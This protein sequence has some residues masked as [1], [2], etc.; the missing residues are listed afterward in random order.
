MPI[1]ILRYAVFGTCE[2]AIQ[3]RRSDD[4]RHLVPRSA[5][6]WYKS[7]TPRVH[8]VVYRILARLLYESAR[9]YVRGWTGSYRAG[10]RIL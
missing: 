6:W 8:S 10:V 5:S 1:P 4:K 7:R 9:I 2:K 3:S